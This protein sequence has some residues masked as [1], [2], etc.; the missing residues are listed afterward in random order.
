[1]RRLSDDKRGL[2]EIV[3]ALMLTLIVVVAAGSFAVFINQKQQSAQQQQLYDQQKQ[4]EALE[5]TGLNPRSSSGYFDQ[6]N[7]SVASNHNLR[8]IVAKLMVNNYTVRNFNASIFGHAPISY[9]YLSNISIE[10]HEQL[11]IMITP[12]DLF[13]NNVKFKSSD[14]VEL[15][16]ST[17]YQNTFSRAFMPPSAVIKLSTESQWNASANH[18]TGNYT[19]YLILDGSGSAA[20][21]GSF[22]VSYQ[23]T[24]QNVSHPSVSI[25]LSGIKVRANF[26][27]IGANWVNLT[28][29]D[30]N[31]MISVGSVIY[32]Y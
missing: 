32:Y 1:M 9:S 16:I 26:P 25:S 8:S 12:N 2:S 15:A 13:G 21:S 18:N 11:N 29:Q 4:Q 3:G 17:D 7:F 31:G 27:T 14:Y 30:N 6:L 5:I 23:W 24:I 20:Q 10:P 22:L 28:V 19:D